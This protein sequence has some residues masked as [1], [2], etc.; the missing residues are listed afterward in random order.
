MGVFG[1]SHF[2]I[3]VS[4]SSKPVKS[5]DS[6]LKLRRNFL[7]CLC[8]QALRRQNF[9]RENMARR[10]LLPVIVMNQWLFIIY[11]LSL[12]LLVT[13]CKKPG[14]NSV[15]GFVPEAPA[16]SRDVA[17]P[18]PVPSTVAGGT[19]TFLLS[20]S[21]LGL[22]GAITVTD[23]IESVSRSGNGALAFSSPIEE[24]SSWEV[25]I[26]GE[27]GHQHCTMTASD[28]S[29]SITC[30]AKS[31]IYPAS[32]NDRLNPG[33]TNPFASTVQGFTNT[34]YEANIVFSQPPAGGGLTQMFKGQFKNG[35]WT[36][37][38]NAN[39]YFDILGKRGSS[40]SIA[41]N[42]RGDLLVNWSGWDGTA[43]CGLGVPCYQVF[44]AEYHNGAWSG[45][46]PANAND[47]ISPDGTDIMSLKSFMD[48][49]GNALVVWAQSNGSHRMI[50]KSEYRSGVWSHP[51]M[52]APISPTG[53]DAVS[54]AV[55]M[56]ESGNAIIVWSQ[57]SHIYKSEFRSGNWT[58]PANLND[59]I[60]PAATTASDP[61]VAMD[62]NGSAIIAWRQMDGANYQVFKSE[63]RN[64]AWTH[65]VDVSDNISPDGQYVFEIVVAMSNNGEAVISWRQRDANNIL[66]VYLSEYR[67]GAWTHPA[68][69]ADHISVAGQSAGD[70][71]PTQEQISMA[72][73]RLG[74]TI[75]AWRQSDGAS[76][77]LFK[78]Q[79]L[80]S[81]W[82]HP[83][84]LSDN[85]SADGKDCYTLHVSI[86]NPGMGLILWTQR[87]LSNDVQVYKAEFR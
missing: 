52:N 10:L 20:G 70:T 1:D 11:V 44:K 61:K 5:L 82:T 17:S 19:R 68:D 28:E 3:V 73:D 33:G 42:Q 51:A 13:A 47:N 22:E 69:L 83:S 87:D 74:N 50:Y 67:S 81:T 80:N 49:S 72:M 60:S 32:L 18:T 43:L 23:G 30:A 24:G 85:L 58:H 56:D 6:C 35:S 57:D 66:Q 27:P 59:Y 79:Y 41:G 46:P 26:T 25:E 64:G 39:S 53:A 9:T 75:L 4:K 29:F 54:P 62:A 36:L 15:S 65:P 86:S 40:A 45:I 2:V 21:V 38:A 78:S 55:A 7:E 12:S 8:S 37:P 34:H 48:E 71:I 31:W 76:Q 84:G 77:Q 14:S 63:F 16:E